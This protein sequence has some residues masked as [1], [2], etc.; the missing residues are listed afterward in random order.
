MNDSH[1]AVAKLQALQI[2]RKTPE[3]AGIAIDGGERDVGK[4][5]QVRRLSANLQRLQLGERTV[6]VLHGDARDPSTWWD[7]APYDR[8]LAD[9]PCS[10]SGVVRRHPDGKWLRRPGDIAAF[11]RDQERI[12]DALWP[13]LA[14]G[15]KLLYV[16]CSVFKAENEARIIDF[17][18]GH[19]DALRETITFPADAIHI[20]G[21]LLP[22][23]SAAV[24]NQDGFFYALLRK[25]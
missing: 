2:G 1:V 12:L 5:E 18:A 23:S 21:Q 8:I 22:S 4:L 10:A 17:L 25:A 6:R 9:V 20:E 14:R 3:T 13:L 7:A 16:T 19:P 15:G 11:V 24:H